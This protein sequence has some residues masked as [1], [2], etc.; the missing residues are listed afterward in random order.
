[1]KADKESIGM[2]KVCCRCGKEMARISSDPL[3]EDLI[4]HGFCDP[5][6]ERLMYEELGEPL[7]EF[8]EKLGVPVLVI[9]PG[10]R[11][12]TANKQACSLLGKDFS[13]IQ[14]YKG[15]EVIECVHARSRD[16][17]GADVHCKTCTIRNTVL[18]TFA[19]GKSFRNI[20]AYPDICVNDEVKTMCLEISTEKVGS[21]VL[22]RIDDLREKGEFQ[23]IRIR[24][25]RS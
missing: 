13:E 1:M 17:C 2:R 14:G 5:C 8:L 10:P 9:E 21:L 4:S 16:G 15:G 24:S 23:Q 6:G 19:S 11:V 18:E 20:S 25:S 12:R 3:D 22:L 7:H